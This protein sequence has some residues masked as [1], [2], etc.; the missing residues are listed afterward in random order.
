MV[1]VTNE[2]IAKFAGLKLRTLRLKAGYTTSEFVK[3]SGCKSEQQLNRCERGINKISLDMLISSLK[4]LNADIPL[5]FNELSTEME[6]RKSKTTKTL[7][8]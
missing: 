8:E 3:L 1:N 5:F 6:A 4:A 2:S 7:K